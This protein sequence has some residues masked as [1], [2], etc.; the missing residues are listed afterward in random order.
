MTDK[1]KTRLAAVGEMIRVWEEEEDRELSSDMLDNIMWQMAILLK[2]F[3][4]QQGNSCEGCPFVLHDPE[5]KDCECK[6]NVGKNELGT[7]PRF[8]EL[9]KRDEIIEETKE[10][11]QSGMPGQEDGMSQ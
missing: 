8:W 5:R 1:K 11:M 6:I 2:S 10:P 3:C 7:A 9:R 4:N